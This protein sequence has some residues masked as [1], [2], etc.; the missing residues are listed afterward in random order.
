MMLTYLIAA[1]LTFSTPASQDY[2]CFPGNYTETTTSL[3]VLPS[4]LDAYEPEVKAVYKLASAHTDV[5][6]W[7]PC[8]CGCGQRAKHENNKD[9]F[10]RE[11]RANGEIVWDTHAA[12]CI[13]CLEIAREASILAE[14]GKST[15]FIRRHIDGKYT[16]AYAKPTPTPMPE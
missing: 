14:Q 15:L 2:Y 16:N 9:C 7:I 12:H 11:I 3:N 1:M 8:Y 6:Q 4:F 5:L 10:I 13:N